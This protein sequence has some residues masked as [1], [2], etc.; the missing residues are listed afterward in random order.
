M[1]ET[2]GAADRALLGELGRVAAVADP[3]PP[4]L[5]EAC[6]ALFAL[7]DLDAELAQLVEDADLA[8]AGVRG[9]STS[10]RLVGYQADGLAVEL[11]V[12]YVGGR[13]SLLGQLVPGTGGERVR[14]D[15]PD[16]LGGEREVDELGCFRVDGLLP[17]LVRVRVER[18]GADPVSTSWMHL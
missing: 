14:V 6:R 15:T 13:V 17:G 1:S 18:P 12:S 3:V 8:G 16:G 10:T 7:R 4:A 11:Q 9:A 2:L 5:I